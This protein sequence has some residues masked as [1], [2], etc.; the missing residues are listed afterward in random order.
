MQRYV[1]LM[2]AVSL[3]GW[4][5]LQADILDSE[6]F[7]SYDSGFEIFDA[8]DWEVAVDSEFAVSVTD[9]G[10]TYSQGAVSVDGG[11]RALD[12]GPDMPSATTNN[13]VDW[14]FDEV[15]ADSL[16]EVW[17]SYLIQT[18]ETASTAIPDIDE[19]RDFFQLHFS[20]DG[21]QAQSVSVVLDNQTPVVDGL[22]R[23]HI[24]RARSGSSGNVTD[25]GR[26]F[27]NTPEETHLVV[28][29][30][31]A[32]N[33]EYETISIFLNPG[34]PLQPA[35][36]TAMATFA[37]V[38][39]TSLAQFTARISALEAED[40]YTIDELKIGESYADVVPVD[41]NFL[42]GDF[43]NDASIGFSDFI[44]L[45]GNLFD[46]S[47]YGE[48]DIDFSGQVDLLDF[49]QFRNVYHAANPAGAAVPEPSGWFL[50]AMTVAG[51]LVVRR[52]RRGVITLSYW[53]S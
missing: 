18:S 23:D 13:F 2:I 17:F 10:L 41:P 46:G 48:G 39:A 30:I 33:G 50:G 40:V 20:A 52:R 53:W 16:G 3:L 12:I 7:E 34:S 5:T 25:P 35:V 51:L 14:I 44:V 15:S 22:G 26:A 43:D 42:L 38:D 36:P 6:D 28:G 24:F 29:Q 9:S 8:D 45:A 21:N 31:E 11:N 49:I 27:R 19:D 47:S 37:G 1:S 32:V 4:G